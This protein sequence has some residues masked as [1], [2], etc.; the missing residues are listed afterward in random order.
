MSLRAV[1]RT[2]ALR[3]S[4]RSAEGLG[5]FSALFVRAAARSRVA[6]GAATA[7]KLRSTRSAAEKKGVTIHVGTVVVDVRG[8]FTVVTCADRLSGFLLCDG[9]GEPIIEHEKLTAPQS[10]PFLKA[11]IDDASIELVDLL[12]AFLL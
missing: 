6:S 1:S 10:L 12:K 11:V 9:D 7:V 8:S 4:M 5:A 2:T 3:V